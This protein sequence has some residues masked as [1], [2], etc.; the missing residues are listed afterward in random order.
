MS[1][2]N[3]WP[4]DGWKGLV[5]YHRDDLKQISS[6]MTAGFRAYSWGGV[7]VGGVLI[8]S[9]DGNSFS[10][11]DHRPVDCEHAHGPSYELTPKDLDSLRK[12]VEAIRAEGLEPVGWYQSVSHRDVV[13]TEADEAAWAELFPDGVLLIL[14]RSKEG[15]GGG[16][17][18]CRADGRIWTGR[19]DLAAEPATTTPSEAD[20]IASPPPEAAA[21]VEF[22]VAEAAAPAQAP[23]EVAEP[24]APAATAAIEPRAPAD[25]FALTPDPE[26]FYP[27]SQHREALASLEY[28]IKSRKG[29][30]MLVGDAGTGKTMLLECLTDRL[31][32]AGSEYGFLFN[33]RVTRLEL[34]ELLAIDFD[35]KPF[36]L[37]KT[38]V[39]MAFNEHLLQ[40]ASLGRTTALLIDDAQELSTDVLEEIK[41]L[42]NL[43]TR[44]GKLLQVVVAGCPEFEARLDQPEMAGLRQRFVLRPRLGPLRVEETAEYIRTRLERAGE[45][46]AVSTLPV[47]EIHRLSGGVPRLI[48][49]ICAQLLE[50]RPSDGRSSL[51]ALEEVADQLGLS[52]A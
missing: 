28:G 42:S 22:P 2:W 26:F 30:I 36:S 19:R 18:F 1:D 45:S 24:A 39:L 48:S 14:K 8:G 37:T 23:I 27:S 6:E 3:E 4:I 21:S 47:E 5:K 9:R 25:A 32:A 38:A 44:K 33:S 7:E 43:E 11:A 20:P 10:I 49:A 51:R 50:R 12:A 31:R 16:A 52:L 41:L 40:R 34:F 29:F 46:A 13:L 35:L 17:T 15:V